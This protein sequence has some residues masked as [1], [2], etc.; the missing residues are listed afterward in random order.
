MSQLV[1][2]LTR[3]GRTRKRAVII[4]FDAAVMLLALWLSILSSRS[5]APESVIQVPATT[6]TQPEPVLPG[7]GGGAAPVQPQ[8]VPSEPSGTGART[9]MPST[10]PWS[11]GITRPIALAAPES[12]NLVSSLCKHLADEGELL[13]FADS[14]PIQALQAILQ[15]T[16]AEFRA[17]REGD[18]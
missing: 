14:E 2:R 13:T 9:E 6:T 17:W 11:S 12:S 3:L 4:A 15:D 10:L 8:G 5:M 7:V 16:H 18:A 1:D